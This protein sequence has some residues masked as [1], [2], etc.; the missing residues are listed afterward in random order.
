M[1]YEEIFNKIDFIQ[2][3]VLT[4]ETYKEIVHLIK[5]SKEI[6]NLEEVAEYAIIF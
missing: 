6:L 5:I 4:S 1:K 3:S 2:N